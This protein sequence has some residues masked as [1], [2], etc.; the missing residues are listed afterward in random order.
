MKNVNLW[1][2]FCDMKKVETDLT[3][4]KLAKKCNI[5]QS[6]LSNIIH[7]I[8]VT[9][10]EK[11]KLAKALNT[12]V[13]VIFP[14]STPVDQ[15]KISYTP[16]VFDFMDTRLPPQIRAF[17]YIQAN[18]IAIGQNSFQ[19]ESIRKA[20]KIIGVTKNTLNAL[21]N[22]LVKDK[23]ITYDKVDQVVTLVKK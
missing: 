8:N 19:L 22:T 13:D 23:F 12:T 2:A 21:L 4:T 17:L 1:N 7:G 10:Q 9:P 6:K 18:T 15:D 5:S 3:I 14:E 16:E 20:E 11:L